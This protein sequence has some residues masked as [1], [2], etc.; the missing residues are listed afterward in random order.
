MGKDRIIA[1]YFIQVSEKKMKSRVK[2][3]TLPKARKLK[4]V[5]SASDLEG[6]KKSQE[7]FPEGTGA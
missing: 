6:K 2:I 3:F 1:K 5:K 4:N 7:L